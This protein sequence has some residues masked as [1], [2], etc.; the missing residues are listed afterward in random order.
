VPIPLH[1]A[2][3]GKV[4]FWDRAAWW[5]LALIG[6]L[7]IPPIYVYVYE[8]VRLRNNP[9]A[10]PF[11]WGNRQPALL[12]LLFIGS[13]IARTLASAACVV[14][15]LNQLNQK[16]DARRALPY[17]LSVLLGIVMMVVEFLSGFWSNMQ[18]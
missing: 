14:V 16:M 6:L 2:Q 7:S 15:A 12:V 4:L 10:Y 11:G 8:F 18:D 9:Y 5:L 17:W 1:Y 13:S 3:P